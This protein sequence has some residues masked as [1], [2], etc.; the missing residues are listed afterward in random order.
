M[1]TAARSFAELLARYEPVIGLEVHAQLLTRTKLFCGCANR[2]GSPPNTHVCPVCLGPPGGAARPQPPGRDPGHT[3]G[4]RD[5]VHGPAGLG[6]RAE[7]LLLPGPAQ[8]LPDLAVRAAAR[9]RRLRLDLRSGRGRSEA[10]PARPH[11]H[12][13]GRR[14]APARGVPVVGR[15]ERRRPQPR[16]GA[17]HRDRD[18]ARPALSR[19]GARLP[20]GAARR[21]SCTP[22]SPTA[23]WRRARCAATPTC[24]CARGAPRRSRRAP[25]SRTSTPSGTSRGRS[26]TRSRGRWRSSSRAARSS[27]RRACGTPSGARRS[28]CAPRRTRTTTGTSPSPTCRRS[29][30]SREWV[31]E[32]RVHAAGASGGEAAPLRGRVRAAGLRRGRPHPGAG[33]GRVLR[34]RRPGERQRQGRLELGDDRGPA[35]AEGGRKRPSPPPPSAPRPWRG[36]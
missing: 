12:G 9:D 33:R 11:P 30:V 19:G 3:G 26:S 25:R 34:G 23:T 31:E 17:P 27:R 8:G 22:S 16:G 35:Q 24:R 21:C 1:A 14:Q 5:G 7:E 6:L 36:W 32:V 4:A 29:C 15:E 20:H 28:R 18:R 2:F 10:G 13:G